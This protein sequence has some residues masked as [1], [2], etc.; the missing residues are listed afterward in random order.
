MDKGCMDWPPFYYSYTKHNNNKKTGRKYL[1]NNNNIH[2][3]YGETQ[4]LGRK[5]SYNE[6]DAKS[7]AKTKNLC[8]GSRH[9][10]DFLHQNELCPDYI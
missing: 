1:S 6:I 9:S 4:W 8:Q 7:M 3:A 2:L 10:V 5:A